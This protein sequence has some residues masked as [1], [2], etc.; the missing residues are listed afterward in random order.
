MRHSARATRRVIAALAAPTAVLLALTGCA[1]AGADAA[2]SE[3]SSE[4]ASTTRIIEH[5]RGE[6][7]VPTAPTRVVVLEPVQLDTSVA[8]GVIP[9][10][11]AVLSEAT[12]IPA[13]LGEPAA[14][15]E[16][17]GTV[18]EPSL[19]KIAALKPDLILGT[20]TRHS[21]LYDQLSAVA[22]TVFMATQTD[23]WQDNVGLVARALGDEAAADELLAEY[24]ERCHDIAAE[25]DTTGTTAQLIRPRDGVLTFYGPTSFAGSTLECAGLTIPER[26]WE[27]SISVDVSPERV[28]EGQADIVLVTTTDVADESTVPESI[29]ANAGAFPDLTL[30]DQ[31]FWIS[32]VGPLGGM[33]VLDDIERILQK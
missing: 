22:P 29:R 14:G 4:V 9:V 8:L 1:A 33:T 24:D 18:A 27:N 3:A 21:A 31:S 19:E 5:A 7:E 6:T 20:E 30:I 32:G 2:P 17:V 25:Y 15:I 26:D 16:M 11:A 10:G 23:P 13:Y 12:G 28:L